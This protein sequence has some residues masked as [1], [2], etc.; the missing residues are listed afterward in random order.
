MATVIARH[1]ES[2]ANASGLVSSDPRRPVALTH[3][4]REQ[5]HGLG[6]QVA[7]L[8]IEFVVATRFRRTQEIPALAVGA[9]PVPVLI[10]PGLDEINPETRGYSLENDW[11]WKD[12]HASADR[13]PNGESADEARI[14]YAAALWRLLSRK[15]GVMLI[16]LHEPLF[17]EDA[18]ERAAVRLG[19][20][21]RPVAPH[22][23]PV[24]RRRHDEDANLR[25]PPRLVTRAACR[26]RTFARTGRAD[27]LPP[28]SVEQRGASRGAGRRPGPEAA[29][30]VH[31]EHAQHGWNRGEDDDAWLMG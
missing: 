4:G 18:V 30:V 2:T 17:E 29:T 10:E 8:D 13:F 27:G 24:T 14:R 16:I 6:P 31:P 19:E 12:S 7:S 1:A 9:R 5:A 15:E 25:D 21:S 23:G 20:M 26:D 3:R 11:A 22:R 28:S